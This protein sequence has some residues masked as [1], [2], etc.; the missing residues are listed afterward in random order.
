MP[1]WGINDKSCQLC[2]KAKGT[3]LHRHECEVTIPP[4]GWF[5]LP[6]N[7]SALRGKLST[8]RRALLDTRGLFVLKV[9]KPRR[10]EYDSF[11]WLSEPPDTTDDSLRWYVDGSLVN[12]TA[13]LLATTGFAI[14]ATDAQSNLVAWGHGTPPALGYRRCRRRSLGPGAGAEA[15]PSHSCRRHRLQ[16]PAWRSR[17]HHLQLRRQEEA[18]ENMDAYQGCLRW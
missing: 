8:Q 16:G 7:V 15:L 1:A 12:G 3:A 13:P 17:R 6:A 14:V 2:G 4:E 5:D 18:R 11:Q 10:P 9:K